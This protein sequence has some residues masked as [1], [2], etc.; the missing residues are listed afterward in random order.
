M[1]KETTKET[2][3]SNDS[4]AIKPQVYFLSDIYCDKSW[5]I[6]SDVAAE[7]SD[8]DNAVT[9]MVGGST[10]F[11][12][13]VFSMADEGQKEPIDIRPNPNHD[14]KSKDPSARPWMV[15]AG[16][17]RYAA[18][19]AIASGM[20][21]KIGDMTVDAFLAKEGL[22]EAKIVSLHTKTPTIV[23]RPH[24]AMTEEQAL[25]FCL[26]ENG[27]RNDVT[28][29]DLCYGVKRLLEANPRIKN[30]EIAHVMGKTP[31]FI[32]SLKNI[33]LAIEKMPGDVKVGAKVDIKDA[34][35]RTIKVKGQGSKEIPLLQA[36]RE[37]KIKLPYR[38][39][40]DAVQNADP[41]KRGQAYE[42]AVKAHGGTRGGGNGNPNPLAW[43]E[44]AK[45]EAK[46]IGGMLAR[47]EIAGVLSFEVDEL[48]N[49][50]TVCL[51]LSPFREYG[52]QKRRGSTVDEKAAWAENMR[53]IGKVMVD[54][55][56]A[57]IL[58]EK[59]ERKKAREEAAKAAAADSAK[60]G[61]A[62]NAP[63]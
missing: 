17:Q 29:P 27:L 33:L 54:G 49:P 6:R 18:R 37:E 39:M 46:S 63:S 41:E 45:G 42:E 12:G 20:T 52:T 51:L 59:E 62:A 3:T 24:K 38:K 32:T 57:A 35:Q 16:H 10:G 31:Q 34:G 9:K 4:A 14:P 55:Y 25:K 61:K 58:Q 1:A 40:L 44:A 5:N 36:W 7:Q 43:V 19:E 13:L 53:S 2:L 8:T 11:P 21:T 60:D 47:C 56:N 30:E 50:E 15:M 22:D 23:A 26:A 28:V 48:T